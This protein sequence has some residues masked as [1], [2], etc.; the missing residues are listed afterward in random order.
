MIKIIDTLL[1]DISL[2]RYISLYSITII[3]CALI[4]QTAIPVMLRF[5]FTLS[6]LAIIGEVLLLI[7]PPFKMWIRMIENS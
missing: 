6:C 2:L 3:L 1:I 5:V 7:K 4:D